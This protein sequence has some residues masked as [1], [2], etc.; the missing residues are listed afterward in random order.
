MREIPLRAVSEGVTLAGSLWLPEGGFAHGLLLMH[1]GS[2]R[3]DRDND[4]LFP[5]IRA[6]VLARNVAVCSFDKRGVGGS[7]GN[8]TD[9]GIQ[10]QAAD[11]VAGLAAARDAMTGAGHDGPV[12]LFGHSQGGW[13][14]LEAARDPQVDF[15]VTN[16]GPAVT[17]A[18]QERYATRARLMAAGWSSDDVDDAL[19]FLGLVFDLADCQ[20]FEEG[21]AV[22]HEQRALA[23]R[24]AALGAFLPDRPELWSL[25]KAILR[26]DPGPAI[27]SLTIPLLALYGASDPIVPV[28][29]SATILR[30]LAHPKLLE[31]RVLPGGDHRLQ[32][33]D[34]GE[35]V[36]D[37]L[38]TVANFVEEQCRRG[39]AR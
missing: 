32:E 3:S 30:S 15:V 25:A 34:S 20:P 37:Y 1:P 29:D 11:L 35:F 27:H 7:G 39:R 23:E 26:Y 8:W 22:L 13:V 2:G 17:P 24:L 36:P 33:P 31:V 9:A 18:E 10:A 14:V 6:A 19:S 21:A 12:G 28:V 4:V 16:S 5:P 38:T